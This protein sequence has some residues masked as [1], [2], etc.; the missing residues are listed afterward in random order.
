MEGCDQNKVFVGGLAWETTEDVLK[1]YFGF[2]GNVVDAVIVK[3]RINGSSRGFGFVSF[4]ESSVLSKVMGESHKILGR[5]VD[6]KKAVR[7][8]A[9]NQNQQEQNREFNR[10]NGITN[11]NDNL[12]T[13]KIFVGGLPAEITEEGFKGY[14]E[15][16]GKIIDVVVMHDNIT[17][18]PRG[19][20][21]ITFDAEDSVEEVIQK[22][23]HELGGKLVEVKKAIPKDDNNV[24]G[25]NGFNSNLPHVPGYDLFSYDGYPNGTGVYGGAYYGGINYGL[26]PISPWGAPTMLTMRGTLN[27]YIAPFYPSYMNNR[28][29]LMGM[30]ANGYNETGSA[31][32]DKLSKLS[33]GSDHHEEDVTLSQIDG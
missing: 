14:F 4:S 33:I 9:Q 24:S 29:G 12:K 17:R 2:Y 21:F 6:V 20:G 16:F 28:R 26:G 27:P 1:E 8:S 25:G 15:K 13:K 3:D 7:R 32:S 5:T 31:P 18:R 30:A 19:F 23:F 10:T 11:N 22:S